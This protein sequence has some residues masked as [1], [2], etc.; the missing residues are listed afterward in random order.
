MGCL[1][2][3]IQIGMFR[4][5]RVTNS[6]QVAIKTGIKL[7]HQ[8]NFLFFSV[9]DAN[10]FL[11][12][13]SR[14]NSTDTEQKKALITNQPVHSPLLSMCL[15]FPRIAITTCIFF[16]LLEVCHQSCRINA[17][18]VYSITSHLSFRM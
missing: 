11:D 15:H 5:I 16:V 2:E 8:R 1:G 14:D 4:P 6:L 18:H 7:I 3:R 13:L 17:K 9:C 12:S 10:S